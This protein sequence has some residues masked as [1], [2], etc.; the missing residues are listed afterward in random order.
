MWSTNL[1]LMEKM[2]SALFLIAEV[3]IDLKVPWCCFGRNHRKSLRFISAINFNIKK[4][5]KWKDAPK[6]PAFRAGS[7]KKQAPVGLWSDLPMFLGLSSLHH[8][9]PTHLRA[10][11]PVTKGN[12]KDNWELPMR[13]GFSQWK[14][15]Q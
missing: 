15:G 12:T 3:K 14:P 8:P 1:A 4:H 13:E 9:S 6:P 11:S 5:H 10:A 2:C 7:S